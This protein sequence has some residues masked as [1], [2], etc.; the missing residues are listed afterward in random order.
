MK[1]EAENTTEKINKTNNQNDQEKKS[2][3][4]NYRCQE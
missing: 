2:K 3:D 4:T 1:Y